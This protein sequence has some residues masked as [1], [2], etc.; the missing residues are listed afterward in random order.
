MGVAK[1]TVLVEKEILCSE[2]HEAAWSISHFQLATSPLPHLFRDELILLMELPTQPLQP[3]QLL[4]H[5]Q[6]SSSWVVVYWAL[7]RFVHPLPKVLSNHILQKQSILIPELV[8]ED[9]P[10]R[11][12][13]FFGR[14]GS[15]VGALNVFLSIKIS[16][17]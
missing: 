15:G 11:A 10:A 1:T 4:E 9:G 16:H 8:G 7:R 12:A 6:T 14:G 3:W 2:E 5:R 13:L 17:N